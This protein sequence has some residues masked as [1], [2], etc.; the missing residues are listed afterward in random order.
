MAATG[1]NKRVNF[2]LSEQ[3]FARALQHVNHNQEKYKNISH[4]A[5]AA[6]IQKVNDEV[7]VDGI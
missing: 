4:L 7:V 3:D 1:Y 5:R 6:L 2:R